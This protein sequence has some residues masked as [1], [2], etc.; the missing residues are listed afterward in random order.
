LKSTSATRLTCL[1]SLPLYAA[2]VLSIG[3]PLR[4]IATDGPAMAGLIAAADDAVTA[5]ANPAGLTR[6]HEAEWV[7]G[8]RAF[9]SGSGFTTTAQS[10]GGSSSSSSSSSLAIPSLYYAPPVNEHIG[11]DLT[12]R[13]IR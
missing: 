12:L 7:G 10:V 6:L 1:V 5:A 2:A 9:Y 4:A 3:L 11:L 13:W 8:I